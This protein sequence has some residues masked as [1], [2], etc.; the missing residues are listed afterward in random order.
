MRTLFL[1]AALLGAATAVQTCTQ[2]IAGK[3]TW[4]SEDEGDAKGQTVSFDPRSQSKHEH[5]ELFF[6]FINILILNFLYSYC[7]SLIMSRKK[8]IWRLTAPETLVSRRTEANV[9]IHPPDRISPP[10]PVTQPHFPVLPKRKP[11]GTQQVVKSI[12][13]PQQQLLGLVL[14]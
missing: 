12:L 14:L 13:Q 6:N 10:T 1:L 11:H 5:K 9:A 4:C 7:P 8:P 3:A 2:A